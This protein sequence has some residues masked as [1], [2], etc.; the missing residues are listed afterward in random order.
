MDLCS[1]M[2]V[3]YAQEGEHFRVSI[4]RYKKFAGVVPTKLTRNFDR[5]YN[6]WIVYPRH[7]RSIIRPSSVYHLVD[8]SYSHLLHHLPE[9]KAGVYCHDLDAFRSILEPGKD[10]RPSWY[11][12]MMRQVFE[13]FKKAKVVFCNSEKTKSEIRQLGHWDNSNIVLAPLGAAEEFSP[14]GNKHQGNYLLHVGS[15]IPRKRIES[16]LRIFSKVHKSYPDLI[17]IQ[18]GGCFSRH[19]L[20]MIKALG[21]NNKVQQKSGLTRDELATL[22][23]G[24]KCLLITSDSE[25]FCL[26]AVEALSCNCPVVC[27][28][29]PVLREVASPLADFCKVD[30]FPEWEEAIKKILLNTDKGYDEADRIQFHQ[31]YSWRSYANTIFNV[32]NKMFENQ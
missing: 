1:E 16:L 6:R 10:P 23:R 20:D 31:K 22:Y 8:H 28:D 27:S 32:Y 5:W 25:G 17:L 13:G 26:P 30:N 14:R 21:L 29:I 7:A 18:A 12:S 15:C 2:L 3:K 9:G 19:H 4:P 11:R 24:A